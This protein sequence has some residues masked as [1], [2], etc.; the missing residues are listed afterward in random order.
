MSCRSSTSRSR[1]RRGAG[2]PISPGVSARERR[3]ADRPRARGV[4]RR[5]RAR[6]EVLPTALRVPRRVRSHGTPALPAGPLRVA[7]TGRRQPFFRAPWFGDSLRLLEQEDVLAGGLSAWVAGSGVTYG[8][9][10]KVCQRE[11]GVSPTALVSRARVQK[12]RMLLAT[13]TLPISAIAHRVGFSTM[14]YF[15]AAFTRELGVPPGR[16]RTLAQRPPDST[17]AGPSGGQRSDRVGVRRATEQIGDPIHVATRRRPVAR[18][19]DSVDRA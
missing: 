2:W 5:A 17:G 14:S 12:A 18:P 11:L 1:R 7:G 13:T 15:Y 3:R 19:P 6:G 9:L 8:H 10:A 4:R 16:Y